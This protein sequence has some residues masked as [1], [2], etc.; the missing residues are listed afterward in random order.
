M[1]AETPAWAPQG[2]AGPRTVKGTQHQETQRIVEE[3][4]AFFSS[5]PLDSLPVA[6]C[7]SWLCFDL[8]Y[9]GEEEFE[10][11]IGGSFLDFARSLPNVEIKEGADG[12]PQLR[13]VPDT[14]GPARTMSMSIST[15]E[16]LWR[17][18]M[19]AEDATLR[20]AEMEFEISASGK[21]RVDAIYQHLAL[22]MWDLT[23][24]AKQ[25][26]GSPDG[27]AI[28]SSVADLSALLDLGKPWTLVLLDPTGRSKI[29]PMDGVKVTPGLTPLESIEETEAAAKA[30]L[31]DVD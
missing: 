11:A 22:A 10:E 23:E 16:D 26:E 25:L 24:H 20:I 31:E 13:V 15:S 9:D 12:V 27:A 8:G 1:T 30:E 17:V 28:A 21:K 6:A 19:K 29:S 7:A 14:P 4:E 3:L 18:L 2:V 5:Q